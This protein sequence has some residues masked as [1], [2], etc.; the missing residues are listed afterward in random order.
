MEFVKGTSTLPLLKGEKV[1]PHESICLPWT[2][3]KIPHSESDSSGPWNDM[4][5]SSAKC[6]THNNLITN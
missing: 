2:V 3:K 6:V 5:T 1:K 4:P